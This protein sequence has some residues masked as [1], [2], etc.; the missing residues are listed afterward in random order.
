M[1]CK[2]IKKI[3]SEYLDGELDEKTQKTVE[4]HLKGCNECTRL[5]ET[6]QKAA[7]SPFKGAERVFPSDA[8]WQNVKEAITE[9]RV[10]FASTLKEDLSNIFTKRRLVPAFASAAVLLI[11]AVLMANIY[12]GKTSVN[13][14]LTDQGDFLIALSADENGEMDFGTN[15][16]EFLL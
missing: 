14:F 13:E 10:G 11:C 6:V 12:F 15:I 4:E 5:T 9:E 7:F 3:I 16:E 8:V 2:H 1:K